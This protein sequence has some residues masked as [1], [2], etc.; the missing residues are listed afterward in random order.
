MFGAGGGEGQG[1]HHALARSGTSGGGEGF[2]EGRAA[3]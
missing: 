1:R 2:T 3:P